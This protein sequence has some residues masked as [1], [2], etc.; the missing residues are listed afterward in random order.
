MRLVASLLN[1]ACRGAYSKPTI[2]SVHKC[3]WSLKEWEMTKQMICSLCGSVGKPKTKTK[4]SIV[5]EIVLW[6][7]V[8]VP[9][10][11]YSLWRLTT[12]HL[13]CP[14]CGAPNMIPLDSPVGREL[15]SKLGSGV[16]SP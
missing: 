7:C 16:S 14:A 12:R 10:L 5:I 15:Q 13:A 3:E 2:D 11:I 4:G 1:D 6:L 8:L 9:G